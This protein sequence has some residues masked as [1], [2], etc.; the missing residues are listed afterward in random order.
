[1]QEAADDDQHLERVWDAFEQILQS[2][3]VD[4]EFP[5]TQTLDRELAETL[6][7]TRKLPRVLRRE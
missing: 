3:D 4:E 6:D 1:M 5:G 2:A 7:M